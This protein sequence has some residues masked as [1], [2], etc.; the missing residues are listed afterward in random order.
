[1]RKPKELT[2][3][4]LLKIATQLQQALY[5]DCDEEDQTWDPDKSW[6]AA[7]ICDDMAK[8]LV[9]LKLAPER[10]NAAGDSPG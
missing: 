6:K 4:E 9:E 5:L 8:L 10:L 3:E 2:R 1:M 7:D